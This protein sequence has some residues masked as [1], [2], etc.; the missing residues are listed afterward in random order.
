MHRR[1][2]ILTALLATLSLVI[3]ACGNSATTSQ[4]PGSSEVAAGQVEIRWFCCLGGGD[5]PEQVA[6]EKKVA[7]DFTAAH[8][9]IKVTFEAVPYDGARDALATE[10]GSGNAPDIVGPVGIGGAEAFHGQW[11][12]LTDLIAK[13]NY[14]L[15]QFPSNIVDIYKLDEGQVGIPFAIYPSP[16]F[17]KRGLF[18]EAGLEEPPHKYGD[19]Y[20]LDGK[21]VEWNYDTARE[22]ALRLTVDKTNKDATQAGFD[23][24]SIVQY[25][26]EAQRDDIRGLGAY[27]GGGSLASSDGKTVQIPDPWLAAWKWWYNGMWTDHFIMTGPV[28]NSTEFNGGGYPF[29]SGKVA[30]SQNFLWSTYGVADAGDDWDLAALPAYNGKATAAFNADTFRIMKDTKHPDEAF[31][32]LSYL[33]DEGSNELLQAYGGMPAREKEQAAFF[34]TLGQSDGFPEKVDWQVAIDGIAQADQ[35]NFEANLPKYNESLDLL[36]KY[37]EKWWSKAGLDIDQEASTLK[38]ELQA[39]WDR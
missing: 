5:A 26:F 30:M 38:D 25:G 24:K 8:P 33:L 3:S 36:V 1:V 18:E 22:V 23:P 12:D 32:V 10:I 16:L 35:P 31:Q 27:F 2:T 4:A 37:R 39:I 7:A 9:N 20:T 19:P 34:D 6:V 11:L 13:N 15:S 21:Q 14:D 17:Y 29:F 28:Y